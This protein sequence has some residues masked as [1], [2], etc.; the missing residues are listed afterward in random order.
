MS[1]QSVLQEIT[2]CS[3]LC[4]LKDI[5]IQYILKLDQSNL[6]TSIASIQVLYGALDI[7]NQTRIYRQQTIISASDSFINISDSSIFNTEANYYHT[8]AINSKLMYQNVEIRNVTQ[9]ENT[10]LILVMSESILQGI[11]LTFKDSNTAIFLVQDSSA[12]I[13]KINFQNIINASSFINFRKAKDIRMSSIDISPTCT[14]LDNYYL[15]E[16]TKNITLTDIEVSGLQKLFFKS[17][18]S[19]FSSIK[20][21]RVDNSHK[22][23]ELTESSVAAMEDCVFID[24]GSN[25]TQNGGAIKISNSKVTINSSLFINNTAISG[26][27]ISFHCTSQEKCSFSVANS[28]FIGNTALEK[29]GAIYYDYQPPVNKDIVYI[30][31]T[32]P[33]GNNLASY[34][35]CISLI[36]KPC[37][38]VLTLNNYGSGIASDTP[39]KFALYDYDGQIMNLDSSS[40]FIISS[41]TVNDGKIMGINNAVLKSGIATFSSILFIAEPGSK[42]VLFKVS[43]R[44]LDKDKLK[45][46]HNKSEAYRQLEINFRKCRPG[47]IKRGEKCEV[48]STGTYSLGWSSA[49]CPKCVE[50]SVCNGGYSISVNHGYWRRTIN[51][52]NIIKCLSEEACEGGFEQSTLTPTKCKEGYE[53]PLCSKCSLVNDSKY[54]RLNEFECA[55][56][57]SL[58]ISLVYVSFKMILV[59]IYFT[60]TIGTNIRKTT[61]NIPFKENEISVLMRIF[62][63][64]IQ[65]VVTSMSM[66]SEYPQFNNTFGSAIKILGGPSRVLI[67][68]DC[69]VPDS[70]IK[71][72]FKSSSE[73]KLFLMMLLPIILFTLF[74]VFWCAAYICGKGFFKNLTKN[75]TISYISIIFLLHPKLTRESLNMWRCVEI[76]D[77]VKVARYNMDLGCYSSEHIKYCALLSLPI[78]VVWVI[79]MPILA[80]IL[81]YKHRKA[82]DHYR[83]KEY[84]LIL[85]QGLTPECF[86]WEFVNIFRKFL[87]LCCLLIDNDYRI[88]L[89][90]FV[91]LAS[92]RWQLY[93]KPYKDENN[94]KVEYL[95]IMSGFTIILS[96]NIF[97]RNSEMQTLNTIMSMIVLT[98]NITFFI[99]WIHLVF[100]IY[101]EKFQIF[102]ILYKITGWLTCKKNMLSSSEATAISNMNEG[103]RVEVV[104]RLRKSKNKRKINRKRKFKKRKRTPKKLI[105]HLPSTSQRFKISSPRLFKKTKAK[106][107]ENRMDLS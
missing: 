58:A 59:I 87:I 53:G 17:Y 51:S 68:F 65:L 60:I 77:D 69:F 19:E 4:Y 85:Y 73:F 91:L 90:L 63:H 106:V 11:N 88:L 83:F 67:S 56:C 99:S 72:P 44:I 10:A 25:S 8:V 54:E 42:S 66:S 97:V 47:E 107:T 84:L 93:L 92:A 27:V 89:S 57:P 16:N 5:L 13:N 3:K 46:V 39:L 22:T 96:I 1:F 12:N 18:N 6:S 30:N 98:I 49:S 101:Q 75:L 15:F 37:D 36:G 61:E 35:Y 76:D 102:M 78:L 29:G 2:S 50:D 32:A 95:S 105:T 71:G 9:S 24:N 74:S 48:C 28:T 104:K 33:Y 23:I 7:L 40:Q 82:E 34:P 80:F 31:N 103:V 38:S 20:N 100:K 70:E 81:L 52:T 55:K 21:L 79:S 45:V 62:T 26:G 86:Y 41:S 14:V 43:S 94:N 64:Y